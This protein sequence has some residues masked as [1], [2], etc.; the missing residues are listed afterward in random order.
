MEI[1]ELHRLSREVSRLDLGGRLADHLDAGAAL[2]QA[3]WHDADAVD[4][5]SEHGEQGRQEGRRRGDR[6]QRDE[7]GTGPHRPHERERH[8]QQ[9][10]QPDRHREAGEEGGAPGGRH[11]PLERRAG[12]FTCAQLLAV[13]EDHE[14]RVVDRDRQS[15]QRD[16]VR[17]V[18]GHVAQVCHDPHEAERR[19]KRGE[20]EGEGNDHRAE[21]AEHEQEHDQR[22]RHGDRLALAEV[23]VVDRLQVVTERRDPREIRAHSRHRTDSP[24]HPLG[25]VFRVRSFQWRLDLDVCHARPG[26]A[27]R[28]CLAVRNLRRSPPGRGLGGGEI[29]PARARLR[30][31][32]ERAIAALV[33]AILKHAQAP[34]GIGARH[35]EAIRE[36]PAH[37][38]RRPPAEQQHHHPRREHEPPVRDDQARPTHHCRRRRAL[39]G[40]WLGHS[41]LRSDGGRSG[42]DDSASA[43]AS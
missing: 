15:D 24:T 26:H 17:D 18:L 12:I 11:R 28:P 29:C 5:G 16:D 40:G 2:Q 35:A 1:G 32:C 21:R 36:E 31:E 30:N 10:G 14:H 9:Q 22:D 25:V 20:H 38:R 27:R 3:A 23:P 33:E 39:S 37:V 43:K 34:F 4:A 6:D 41:P 7:D 8:E 42:R 13:A 19:R